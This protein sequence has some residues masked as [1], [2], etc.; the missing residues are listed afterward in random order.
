LYTF[1]D[2]VFT[3][4]KSPLSDDFSLA[5]I[6]DD[7]LKL[8]EKIPDD[9]LDITV[10]NKSQLV[11]KGKR[12]SAGVTA[13]DEILLPYDV[14]PVPK[15]KSAFSALSDEVP[16]ML[17]QAARTC[18]R[19]VTQ[20][21]TMLV[22]ATPDLIEACDNW[23]LF[24]FTAPVGTGFDNE[25]L[26]PAMSI[27]QLSG[28]DIKTVAVNDGWVHF[29]QD[30]GA[31]ISLRC[32]PESYHDGIDDLLDIGDGARQMKLP[33]NLTDIISRTAIMMSTEEVP[34]IRLTLMDGAVVMES[35]KASGWYKEKKRIK[36]KG[37]EMVFD[38]HPKFLIELLERTREVY[39]NDGSRIKIQTG[40]IEF[41]VAL[42]QPE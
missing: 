22:H 11:I 29:R 30:D 15:K 39:I 17:Q 16:S 38:V 4:Q 21:L 34:N 18:G 33:A 2:E 5:V 36:Y 1:N 27:L 23:R 6:A 12:R 37:D 41:V 9:E 28:L 42:E 32:S 8:V 20:E 13:Y 7:L 35:R 14:V 25:A 19:D 24:R 3:F 10:N 31:V 26:I 40:D